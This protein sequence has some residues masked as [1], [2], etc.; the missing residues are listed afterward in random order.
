MKRMF[1]VICILA[2]LIC[3]LHTLALGE[4]SG[5]Q[6]QYALSVGAAVRVITPTIEKG[7][8]PALRRSE[9]GYFE[10]V[11]VVDDIHVRVIAL[12]DGTTNSL[13]ICTESGGAPQP[14]YFLPILSEHTGIDIDAIFYTATH[15]HACPEIGGEPDATDEYGQ[16]LLIWR[17]YI[18]EQML[19]ACDEAIAEMQPATV[20]VGHG[21]SYININRSATYV[22]YNEDGSSYTYKDL[23]YN[24]SGSSDKELI[25]VRFDAMDGNPIAF[26]V[27]Y[28]VHGVVMHMNK[29]IDGEMGLSADIP[30]LV[31]SYMEKNY[32]GSVA[33]WISGAAGDQNPIIMNEMYRVNPE[34]GEKV[35]YHIPGGSYDILEYLSE[36]QYRDV[37]DTLANIDT[38]NADVKIS[39][40]RN[41]ID[42]P[43][44]EATRIDKYTYEYAD[45]DEPY[46]MALQMLRIGDIAFVGYPGEL[47]SSIGEYMKRSA[48]VPTKMPLVRVRL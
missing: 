40:E 22:G 46:T 42:L 14:A 12:S 27:N 34:T 37:V 5:A 1:C 30:G 16:R 15:S 9:E 38:M 31:S 6:S 24:G 48:L 35:L 25:V 44:Q 23:G 32:E 29:L 33:M 28:A 21:S 7:M 13:M 36:I 19:D 8:L 17:E 18:L 3:G 2:I 26:V 11:D 4:E 41:T 20:G 45:S 10:V 47:F 39:Y 43:G